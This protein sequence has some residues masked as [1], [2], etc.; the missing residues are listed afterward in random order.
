MVKKEFFTFPV[1]AIKWRSKVKPARSIYPGLQ[2][3]CWPLEAVS[4]VPVAQKSLVSHLRNERNTIN[5]ELG[6]NGKTLV[7]VDSVLFLV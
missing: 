3:G 5:L 2:R 1:K 4:V 7:Q 6:Q